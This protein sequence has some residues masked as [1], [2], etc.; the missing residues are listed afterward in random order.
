M[1]FSTSS[2]RF[3]A[4][5]LPLSHTKPNA[6]HDM[7]GEELSEGSTYRSTSHWPSTIALSCL[8]VSHLPQP[9]PHDVRG[10][11]MRGQ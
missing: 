1:F 5:T 10:K 2:S 11:A 6:C 4:A 3:A 7:R 9:S 8:S